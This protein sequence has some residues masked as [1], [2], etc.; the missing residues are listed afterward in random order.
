L[1]EV[2]EKEWFFGI[3]PMIAAKVYSRVL[4]GDYT[5]ARKYC[6]HGQLP[7]GLHLWAQGHK[8]KIDTKPR[9]EKVAA[10][11]GESM[12]VYDKPMM[13]GN[14]LREAFTKLGYR[15]VDSKQLSEK[16]E[17]PDVCIV[18]NN[19]TANSAASVEQAK[20]I[21][22][23][24]LIMELGFVDRA[25]HCQID[26]NGFSHNAGWRHNLRFDIDDTQLEKVNKRFPNRKQVKAR[27][28][29]I[30]VLGQVSGDTQLLDSEITGMPQL[31]KVIARNLPA[32]REVFFRPHPIAADN[33]HPNHARLP[34]MPLNDGDNVEY[35]KTQQSNSLNDALKGAAF[36]I[37]I[38]STAIVEA[39]LAGVPCMAFGPSLAIDAGLALRTS[40]DSYI[41]D[42]QR[43]IDGWEPEQKAVD[44]FLYGMLSNQHHIDSLK[45]PE[46][47]QKIMEVAT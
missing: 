30:L 27:D 43:M 12:L 5:A 26:S 2:A 31:E 33:A 23:K 6:T 17:I 44:R 20:C 19:K 16:S 9:P 13:F 37:T 18:W 36:C 3:G 14:S 40:Q 32:G 22:A 38:N 29:Y 28:G 45:D 42:L 10:F 24:V 25:N 21:G 39:T 15:I 4:V 11:C 46:Y 47:V 8:D 7:F 34:R 41:A 1:V 35:R